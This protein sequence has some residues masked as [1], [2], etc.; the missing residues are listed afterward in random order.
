MHI[1]SELHMNICCGMKRVPT[2]YHKS[3]V[4]SNPF[5]HV[6]IQVSRLYKHVTD[7]LKLFLRE[8]YML[9]RHQ[10]LSLQNPSCVGL[11]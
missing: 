11:F 7:R 1:F 5:M 8:F 6:D 10:T 2:D 9:A 4:N 3:G